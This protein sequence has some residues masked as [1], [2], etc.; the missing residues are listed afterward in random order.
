ML[1]ALKNFG[2][3]FLIAAVVFGVIAYFATGFVTNTV[4]DILENEK[5]QLDE[6]MQNPDSGDAVTET[7]G[8]DTDPVTEELPNGVSFNFLVLT[9]N[10]R[11]DLYDDYEPTLE[12]M[13]DKNASTA[14]PK[15][16]V[17]C[18]TGNYRKKSV[19]SIVLVRADRERRQFIYS[20]LTPEMRVY[21]DTGYHTLSEVY[22]LYGADKFLEHV[23][24][25]TG[26]SVSYTFMLNGYN[27][28]EFIE[29]LGPTNAYLAKDLY[30]NGDI[31]TT[32]PETQ[33]EHI[34]EDGWK[35]YDH[36]YH[37][38][39]LSTGTV[40][41]GSD[42]LYKILSFVE[43]DQSD[44]KAKETFAITVLENYLHSL[45]SLD[46]T[47]RRTMI[48]DLITTSAY[49]VDGN[50]ED[51]PFDTTPM[52]PEEQAQGTDEAKDEKF[53]SAAVMEPDTAI[54]E[55]GFTLDNYEITREMFEAI[56]RFET[57][58]LAYPCTYVSATDM[59]DG[60]FEPD[61]QKAIEMFLPY[62]EIM[63]PEEQ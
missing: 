40:S 20:Y 6:I 3:T 58:T 11:S 1:S 53:W 4:T 21:T 27:M 16:T 47:A 35:W 63:L 22:Y 39:A 41:T 37:T 8:T 36:L 10:D 12:T 18:L 31:F 13:Y 2:V 9:T 46:K 62:R 61:V 19:S 7:T 33:I 51:L 60:Y 34:G 56:T 59:A 32:S 28:D 52:T 15:D 57:V 38:L 54:I 26:M 25:L 23:H 29:K 55:T 48:S 50:Q 14:D 45:V 49:T 5:T 30:T 24:A 17:G 42:N 44:C 43:A